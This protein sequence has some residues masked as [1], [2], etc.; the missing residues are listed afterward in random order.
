[1]TLWPPLK[2]L[3]NLPS[4]MR[5]LQAGHITLLECERANHCVL[6]ESTVDT[7]A[8]VPYKT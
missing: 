1:M 7:F 5:F 2:L 8:S 4:Q 3:V 6:S